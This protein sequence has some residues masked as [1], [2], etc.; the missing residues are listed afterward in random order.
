V[1]GSHRGAGEGSV[2]LPHGIVPVASQSFRSSTLISFTLESSGP[3][4]VD[5]LDVRG[6][7]VKRVADGSF[8]A[9]A[10]DLPWHGKDELGVAVSPGMYFYRLTTPAIQAS[11]KAMRI[12]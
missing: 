12:R 9:G 10:H 2:V 6:R 3:V 8:S 5:V 7:L 11:G 4:R 1:R